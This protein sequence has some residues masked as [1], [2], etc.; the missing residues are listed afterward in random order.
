MQEIGV[1]VS[2]SIED[3]EKAQI[4]IL[5]YEAL[6]FCNTQA[7][8][9]SYMIRKAINRKANLA[10]VAQQYI[11]KRP[12]SSLC[13]GMPKTW[14]LPAHVDF[15]EALIDEVYEVAQALPNGDHFVWKPN[16]TSG[17]DGI[18][19]FNSL[20]ELEQLCNERQDSQ[21]II[22]QE[23]IMD[24]LLPP[25]FKHKF[26]IRVYVVCV[27]RL[28][29][30]VYRDMLA[31]FAAKP[32]EATHDPEVQLTNTCKSANFDF[33][34]RFWNLD[35]YGLD[36]EQLDKIYAQI[37][38]L[39]RD[40]FDAAVGNP[41]W[42]APL[43]NAYEVYGFDFMVGSSGDVWLLEANAYPDF[44]QTGDELSSLI[45]GLFSKVAHFAVLPFILKSTVHSTDIDF[46]QV[47]SLNKSMANWQHD[48]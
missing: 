44:A 24:V 1:E 34:K 28:H 25:G 16:M 37:K 14:V 19:F 47:Y 5:E 33:V 26:H 45:Y 10:L 22:I 31:L 4:H 36:K 15:E 39:V 48:S 29:V 6:D 20:Q 38:A 23:C 32:F 12:Q 27:G 11:A 9:N 40:L 13:F 8:L 3:K 7:L 18:R 2:N 35:E 21:E 41:S 17:G 46:E 30:F 42:F 43:D